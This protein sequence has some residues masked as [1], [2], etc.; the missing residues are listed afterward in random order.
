MAA[1]LIPGSFDPFTIGH[2]RIA[3]AASQLFSNVVIGIARNP[4]KPESMFS[5]STRVKVIEASV[6]DINRGNIIVATYDGATV[7]YCSEN[8]IEYIVRGCRNGSEFD[9]E[10]INKC[11]NDSLSHKAIQTIILPTDPTVSY[12]SSTLVR[13]CIDQ[14]LDKWKSYVMKEAVPIIENALADKHT[15]NELLWHL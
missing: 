9:R 2:F 14:E 15:L 13:R 11:I 1:C 3:M 6:A 5:L 8:K 10:L 12:V 4:D 7:S